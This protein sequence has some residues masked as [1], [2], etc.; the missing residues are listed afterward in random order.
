MR[1]SIDVRRHR[2]VLFDLDGVVT[3]T[4]VVHA[5]AWRDLFD[6][7]F[8]RR[9]ARPGED[10]SPFTDTDYLHYVDGKSRLDGVRDFLAARNVSLP[11]GDPDDDGESTIYGLANR[12]QAA[13]LR[14]LEHGVPAFETTVALICRL[15][16]AGVAVAIYSASRNCRQVLRVAGVEDLFP[17]VVDGVEAERLGLPGKPD[18]AVLIEAARR[19]G[20]PPDRSVVVEDAEAGVQ[21]GH[22]GGFALVIGVDRHGPEDSAAEAL[23]S[24]G[25]DTVVTDLG[26]VGVRNGFV[27]ATALPDARGCFDEIATLLIG[28]TPAVIVESR[29]L[30]GPAP[31]LARLAAHCPVATVG[32]EP[33]ATAGVRHL[34]EFT[35]LASA[36]E[37]MSDDGT[38]LLPIVVGS[39]PGAEDGFD[40][41]RFHGVGIVV[42]TGDDAARPTA[43]RFALDAPQH[44]RALLDRLADHL[45]TVTAQVDDPWLLTFEGYHPDQERLREALCTTGNGVF[46]TRGCAP[47]ARPGVHHYPGTYHAGIF[48]RLSDTVSGKQVD[49]E[50]MVNLPNWLALTFRVD[51]GPWF[52][53]DGVEVLAYHQRIDLQRAV[54]IR[55]FRVRDDDGRITR[56][57]QRRF[58]SMHCPHVAALECILVAENYSGNVEFLTAVDIDVENDGVARYRGLSGRHL[59]IRE[60]GELGADSVVVAADTVQSRIGVAVGARTTFWGP[61]GPAAVTRRFFSDDHRVGHV[62]AVPVTGGE[63]VTV[64]KTAVLMTDR[65]PAMAESAEQARRCLPGLGR[66]AE[67]Y[68]AHC[69]SWDRLWE[70]LY[71]D[72]DADLDDL[73]VLRFHLMHMLQTVSTHTGDLDAGVPARGL[74]GEAYRGHIFWDEL[75]VFPVLNLRIPSVTRALL[76]YRYRRLPAARRAAAEAGHRGAMFPWQSGND[77]SED[78]QRLHLNPMS[79]RWNPDASFRAHHIGIAVAYNVWQYY[80]STGDVDFLVAEGAEMMVDIARFWVSLAR[81]DPDRDRYVIR[82]VI[83][84]DEFHSGYPGRPFEGVDNNAYTNVMATWVITRALDAL[85]LLAFGDRLALVE[86]LGLSE[87]ELARFDDVSRR[88]FV[89]FHDGVISQFEG[90]A[91][92]E[93][94]DWDEYRRRYTDIARLDRILESEN[95]DINR[96]KAAKQADVLMLLY[97]LSA[98]ELR[99]L[100]DRLGYRFTPDQIP[101]T[102]EYYLQRTSHG[103]TLSAVVHAWVLARGNRHQAM[104]FFGDVLRSDLTDIQGGTTAEGIHLA[105]MAG[106]IDL[107][108]RC[109]TGL[110]MRADRLVLNPMWPESL[111]PLVFP[112]YY[113]GQR[114]HVRVLGRGVEVS[115]DS[116]HAMSVKVQCHGRVRRLAAG[117][118][119][120]FD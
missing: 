97:L 25:A 91:E 77:G 15:R 44:V 52:D 116:D 65:D 47:E 2:A 56:L 59:A 67:L 24:C 8:A 16:A 80:Q 115:A 98:D 75:F 106:S 86:R 4:A 11:E 100:L 22:R 76:T 18:P 102:V 48:N 83:G 41:V 120:R 113:R 68:G 34:G 1:V 69:T 105:A 7:M 5:A 94:L 19:L 30:D 62:V 93:E 10:A 46:A 64:E 108:Q 42:G 74:H 92:L 60:A 103:S 37:A 31:E 114:L 51:G 66:F 20:V 28:R 13:F 57:T 63:P 55:E 23:R 78:S 96:Y 17:V 117:N 61:D 53:I 82:G 21:A 50:S 101:R 118:T 71:I 40:R 110:E 107:V 12:K 81:F 45:D 58:T 3:D 84:P 26:E 29:L 39:G 33:D 79:G 14:A 6:G 35:D 9:G 32:G 87:E 104:K 109:F 73:R 111:G 90:Y 72:L 54:L 70:Q 85:A 99:E 38:R 36:V 88:M 112:I 49:N 89:P 43:A 119:I 27:P 95:D